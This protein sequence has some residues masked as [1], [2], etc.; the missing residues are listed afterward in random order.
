VSERGEPLHNT[1]YSALESSWITRDLAD[2]A[3]LRRVS[4]PDGA[5]IVGRRDNGSYSGIV[6]VYVWPG[7]DRIR[8]YWL[9]LDRP[10]VRYDAGGNP[11]EQNKYIGPPGRGNL[12]YI[13]PGTQSE[14][15][16]DV[17]VPVAITEGAKKTLA[18]HR[19]SLNDLA[20]G[21]PP[22]LLPVGLSGV[23]SFRGKIEK[24]QDLM[25]PHAMKRA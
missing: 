22:R 25:A 20:A 11:K 19:L 6:F 15:L 7:E 12:L 13:T 8:E 21:D 4:S 9:R 24:L 3:R 17:R 14:L 18:V 23:W 1:D 10:E 16:N 5:E 2:Q